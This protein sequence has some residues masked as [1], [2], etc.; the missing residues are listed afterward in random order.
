MGEGDK[1]R[2]HQAAVIR[3]RWAADVATVYE[4]GGRGRKLQLP[5]QA[6]ATES[7]AADQER[8]GGG[9]QAECKSL[10]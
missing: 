8:N 5:A 3:L 9:G 10:G 7:A 2:Q 1:I 4:A 6:E